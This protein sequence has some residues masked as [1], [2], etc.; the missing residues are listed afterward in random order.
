MLTAFHHC[1][2]KSE[3]T[4]LIVFALGTYII[5]PNTGVASLLQS[6]CSDCQLAMV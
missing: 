1:H 4:R 3:W 5:Y 2:G 6:R